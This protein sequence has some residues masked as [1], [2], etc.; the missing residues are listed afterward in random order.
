ME[1]QALV[2]S[3]KVLMSPLHI[4]LGLVK[5]FVKALN[6]EG[7]AFKH[8]SDM[9]SHLSKANIEGIFTG[10]DIR[11]MLRSQKCERKTIL[12]VSNVALLEMFRLV[13][14]PCLRCSG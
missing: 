6:T 9:F 2:E 7:E 8:L 5:Q 10:P 12:Q 13:M 4:K 3:E 11:K 14:L 1:Y